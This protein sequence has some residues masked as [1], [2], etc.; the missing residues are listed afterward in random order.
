M[1][2]TRQGNNIH[3]DVTN[4]LLLSLSAVSRASNCVQDAQILILDTKFECVNLDAQIVLFGH[5]KSKHWHPIS[6]FQK[7]ISNL[8]NEIQASASKQILKMFSNANQMH[9]LTSFLA[10][11]FLATSYLEN[12]DY[13]ASINSVEVVYN[14]NQHSP[15]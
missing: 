14:R 15:S 5:T 10:I 1:S 3:W 4:S 2:F 6:G 9:E 8:V 11:I 12:Q 13:G 7:L